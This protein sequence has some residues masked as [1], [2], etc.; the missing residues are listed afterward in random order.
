MCSASSTLRSDLFGLV[1]QGQ[2]IVNYL[3]HG[4]TYIWGTT[5]EL[6]ATADI[7][8]NWTTTGSRLPFVIAMN[9]LNG[10]FQG[11]YG[12]ESLAETL[13]R[14]G[15][16]AVAV[17]ASS[18]LTDAEPQGV[19]NDELFKLVFN[20]SQATLGDAVTAAKGAMANPDV[21]RSWV[22]F[23]DPAM[24][25]KGV[26]VSTD[27]PAGRAD[28]VRD[29]I[30]P[31]LRRGD[32]GR[33]LDIGYAQPVGAGHTNRRRHG[34]LDGL[35]RSTLDSSDERFGY[36]ERSLHDRSRCRPVCH[37]AGRPPAP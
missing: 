21:R 34:D 10:F 19:M 24:R 26:P 14:H 20:G 9:C 18:S 23:G 17:W 15:G 29:A 31:E 25:L 3:G 5:G 12:E 36:G 7:G 27:P 35:G 4:S 6:L 30:E 2:L 22:F 28:A 1:N 32:G 13:M 11:I 16:G 8:S 37:R 33:S